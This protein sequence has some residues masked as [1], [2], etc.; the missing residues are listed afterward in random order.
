MRI[1]RSTLVAVVAVAGLCLPLGAPVASATTDTQGPQVLDIQI[2]PS[3]VSVTGMGTQLVTVR[4]HL[5][6]QT[7]VCVGCRVE[8]DPMADFLGFVSPFLQLSQTSGTGGSNLF[9]ALNLEG[10]TLVSGTVQDGWWQT[11]RTVSAPWNGT[12]RVTKA[13]AVDTAPAGPNGGNITD[14]DPS[15]IGLTRTLTVASTNPPDI[16]LGY[17]PPALPRGQTTFTVKGRAYLSASGAPV[18]NQTVWYCEDNECGA[19]GFLAARGHTTTDVNGYYSFP[20]LIANNFVRVFRLGPPGGVVFAVHQGDGPP[21]V[22]AIAAAMARS[23]VPLGT[24]VQ[25]NG[26]S[27]PVSGPLVYLQRLVGSAWL[28][29]SLADVRAS[30]RFTLIAQ[31]PARGNNRY[32]VL[33]GASTTPTLLLG[34]F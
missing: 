11:T 8:Q 1:R 31:P 15:T 4:V 16:S 5:S 3:S 19:D 20:G 25:V 6:D 30:G 7:G 9:P 26:T 18:A 33:R 23:P 22:Y 2:S 14:L 17:A 27:S 32:R 24:A 12:F 13:A 28:T 10:L 21:P 34:V 29:E